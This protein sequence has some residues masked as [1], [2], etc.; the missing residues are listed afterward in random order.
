MLYRLAVP[1]IM[2]GVISGCSNDNQTTIPK[3]PKFDEPRLIEGRSVWMGT[4]R[5]CHLMGVAGAPAIT[6][7]VAWTP[8]LEKGKQALYDSALQ[9][10]KRNESW[11][12]PPQGGN[13]SLT[14]EQVRSAVD[15]MLATV[16]KLAT[17][18]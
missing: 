12:M 9:G 11:A 3:P 10:I 4:C 5:N 14:P 7:S 1:L 16:D 2:I 6:N 15:Y 13:P 8:R 18:K 17:Q